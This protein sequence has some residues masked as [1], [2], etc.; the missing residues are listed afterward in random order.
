LIT[1]ID[2]LALDHDPGLDWGS[3]SADG[4][5]FGYH[6]DDLNLPLGN[7]VADVRVEEATYGSGH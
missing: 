3:M 4:P 2:P 5:T 7:L 1:S 6:L